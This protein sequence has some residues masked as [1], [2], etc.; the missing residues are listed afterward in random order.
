MR[1]LVFHQAASRTRT[2]DVSS[3]LPGQRLALITLVSA[4]TWGTLLWVMTPS[5]VVTRERIASSISRVTSSGGIRDVRMTIRPP[6]YSGLAPTTLSNPDRIEALRGSR[7][8]LDVESSIPLEV[9]QGNDTLPL[10][11]VDGVHRADLLVRE[12][13]F[14]VVRA[15]GNDVTS[16]RRLIGVTAIDDHQPIVRVT[17][18][19]RDLFLLDSTANIDVAVEA[20]DDLRLA[21]LRLR[22]TKVSGS[23]ER[24]TFTE[25]EIPIAIQRASQSQW[26]AR[27]QLRLQQLGLAR[28]DMVVYRAVATDARP[29][30]A[31][32]E[33][34]AF[35]IEIIGVGGDAAAGFSIDP[36]Q[37]R[38]AVSQQMVILKTER[39][40]ARKAQ[41][42]AEAL[43]DAS[44]ELSV[45]QRRVRAEF[46][47]MMG[48]ELAE[49]ITADNSMG[50]LDETH[51]AES[52]SDLSAGR[53]ANRGRTALLAAIRA[54]SRAA[55]ALNVAELER[56][57]VH[58]RTA[59]RELE[60]AFSRTRYLLRAFTE[61]EE[62]DLARRLTGNLEEA[63]SSQRSVL[64]PDD[65]A[66]RQLRLTLD[67]LAAGTPAS[68]ELA[69]AAEHLLAVDPSS[70]E[71][72]AV[73]MQL[74]RAARMSPSDKAWRALVDSATLAV[75]RLM[76]RSTLVG[77]ASTGGDRDARRLQGAL[78]DAINRDA[79]FRRRDQQPSR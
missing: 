7:V 66:S 22:Y 14:V 79:A 64:I 71:L 29:G 58:G 19:G 67:R 25:G 60:S 55:T 33:S 1:S 11:E 44:R 63:R 37:D 21:S 54:M 27:G 72:Q 35:I 38:Y 40:L 9:I 30:V 52:E 26:S 5:G 20:S 15:T 57:L 53:M 16:E 77:P 45:E 3:V 34:D 78:F 8:Q 39:L 28:G 50:D 68:S 47:F 43:L 75:A 61:R 42:T 73:S 46:V 4:V 17:R 10:R 70:S 69:M 36:E 51:E 41:M 65:D 12:N 18:P 62:L 56:G 76:Q 24:F 59:V 6:A 49:E 74:S 2:L 23:G 31:P 32:Q 48:G 13:G